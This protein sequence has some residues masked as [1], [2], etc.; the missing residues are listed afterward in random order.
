LRDYLLLLSTP[1][2]TLIFAVAFFVIWQR[3][4]TR[5]ENLAL[6]AGWGL[7]T[8]GFLISQLSPDHWARAIVA[9]THVPYTLAAIMIAWGVLHRVGVAAPVR[10]MLAIAVTGIVTMTATQAVGNSIVADIYV[11]NLTCGAITLMAAQLF[12]GAR[13]RD[14]VETFV[15][16]MLALTALQF[17]VRPVLSLLN[18]GPIAADSYRET[19]YGCLRSERY[20][21]ASR[22]WPPASKI[23]SRPCAKAVPQM[24]SPD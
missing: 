11:T 19:A 9:I 23:S 22:R 10:A 15:L 17:F 13:Q 5:V 6:G 7:L 18:E 2:L 21:S 3:D 24:R 14:W 12:S 1:L 20:C 4:R 8:I 16:V